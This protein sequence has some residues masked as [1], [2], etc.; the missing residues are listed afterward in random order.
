MGNDLVIVATLRRPAALRCADGWLST[1]IHTLSQGLDN[2]SAAHGESITR[3][4]AGGRASGWV[5][6]TSLDRADKTQKRVW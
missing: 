2:L 6:A 5:S 3:P 4:G 1:Q